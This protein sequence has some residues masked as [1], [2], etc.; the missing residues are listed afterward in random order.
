ML[1]Y[2]EVQHSSGAVKITNDSLS[3]DG[4]FLLNLKVEAL[5]E[6]ALSFFGQSTSLGGPE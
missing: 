2:L 4:L 6:E 3:R 5:A 1:Y